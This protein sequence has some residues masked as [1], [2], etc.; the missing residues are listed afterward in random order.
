VAELRRL[1]NSTVV[2][3]RPGRGAAVIEISAIAIAFGLIAGAIA[4]GFRHAAPQPGLPVV[5]GGD[6]TARA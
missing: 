1:K 2:K 6:T 4:M 3:A 5:W